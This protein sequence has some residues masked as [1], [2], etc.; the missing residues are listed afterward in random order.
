MENPEGWLTRVAI[1]MANSFFRRNAAESRARARVQ[2]DAMSRITESLPN[3]YLD[4]RRAVAALPTRQ[5]LALLLRYF[6]DLSV[7]ETAEVMGCPEGTVK[8]LTH[9]AIGRLRKVMEIPR[10]EEVPG[11]R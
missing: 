4:V 11:E 3:G 6:E 2:A 10:L 5:R 8:T 7:R 9:R 1:N